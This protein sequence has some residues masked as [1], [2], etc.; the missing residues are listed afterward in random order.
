MD[1]AVPCVQRIGA[2]DH[3]VRCPV[4]PLL[5]C[6]EFSTAVQCLFDSSSV[7]SLAW[8]FEVE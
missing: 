4:L 5:N 8:C 2:C 6:E 3:A 1:D 7:V